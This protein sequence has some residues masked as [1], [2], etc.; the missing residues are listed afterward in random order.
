MVG[1]SVLISYLRAVLFAV[2]SQTRYITGTTIFISYNSL[3]TITRL[4]AKKIQ[5]IY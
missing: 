1:K 2:Y 4:L 3:T 5:V